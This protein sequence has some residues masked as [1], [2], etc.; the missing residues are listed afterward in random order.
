MRLASNTTN[1]ARHILLAANRSRLMPMTNHLQRAGYT[2]QREE[3]LDFANAPN[4]ETHWDWII[5]D[6][7]LPKT[8]I[9]GFCDQFHAGLWSGQGITLL[10]DTALSH[11]HRAKLCKTLGA[12]NCIDYTD[13]MPVIQSAIETGLAHES[14]TTESAEGPPAVT[15]LLEHI[16]T[17]WNANDY[18]VL[19][20]SREDSAETIESA[21]RLLALNLHPDR[22]RHIKGQNQALFERL[23]R[24]FKRVNEVYLRLSDPQQRNLYDLELWV[25][26]RSQSALTKWGVRKDVELQMCKTARGRALVS[27]SLKER[28][29][30]QW[31]SAEQSMVQAVAIEG[32]DSGLVDVLESVRLIRDLTKS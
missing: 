8:L 24:V 3:G 27:Q 25:R 31:D 7:D 11:E 21:Y 13:P 10:V 4:G 2:V 28:F 23:N 26:A 30:G 20:V 6:I 19:G 29:F 15:A 5:L 22:H 9:K 1:G 12:H 14:T 32:N 17:Q 18:I 16:E